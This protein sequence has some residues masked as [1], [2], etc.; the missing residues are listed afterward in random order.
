MNDKVKEVGRIKWSW[1]ANEIREIAGDYLKVIQA[2]K[3]IL[4]N[5]ETSESL[6]LSW[7]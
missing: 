7:F 4:E 1:T 2:K 5:L 6:K 3:L